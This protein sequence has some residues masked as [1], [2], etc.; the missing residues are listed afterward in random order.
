MKT[1]LFNIGDK[2]KFINRPI[3]GI[4]D[5][6]GFNPVTNEVTYTVLIKNYRISD[7]LRLISA[8]QSTLIFDV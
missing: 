3:K 2:V 1:N 6:I 7:D 5:E 8:L 4:V